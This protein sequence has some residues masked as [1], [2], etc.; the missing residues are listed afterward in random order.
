MQWGSGGSNNSLKLGLNKLRFVT[1][2]GRTFAV[3]LHLS[4]LVGGQM[5]YVIGAFV[6]SYILMN[7]FDRQ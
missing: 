2:A 1:N 3:E 7:K 4:G 5:V 6:G